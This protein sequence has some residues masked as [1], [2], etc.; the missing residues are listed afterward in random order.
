MQILAEREGGPFWEYKGASP[1]HSFQIVRLTV[2]QR[3]MFT[4]EV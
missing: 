3:C 2:A 1:P 4:K